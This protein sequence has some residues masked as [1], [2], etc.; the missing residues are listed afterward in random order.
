MTSLLKK[1]KDK[2]L[3][4]PFNDTEPEVNHCSARRSPA[5]RPLVRT[6]T[7]EW[8]ATPVTAVTC[9]TVAS[10]SQSTRTSDPAP[11]G[12]SVCDS[13]TV[14]VYCSALF[15]CVCVWEISFCTAA[16]QNVS[17]L[18]LTFVSE[19]S[20]L[21]DFR[22]KMFWKSLG[23]HPWFGSRSFFSR[24]ILDPLWPLIISYVTHHTSVL[25]NSL[26]MFCFF[27]NLQKCGCM[28]CGPWDVS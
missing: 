16:F 14:P 2:S 4:Y 7:C 19:N 24:P 17:V 1:K 25:P 6:V 27:L 20:L 5:R 28:R 26:I 10:E 22:I 9:T 11:H 8:R 15:V 21:W 18:L 3:N 12:L 23:N 13:V